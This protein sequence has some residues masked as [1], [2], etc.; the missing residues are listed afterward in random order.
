MVSQQWSARLRKA[1]R[2]L[3]YLAVI[4]YL[5]ALYSKIS[6]MQSDVSAM[7]S[8]I[9]SLGDGTCTNPRLCE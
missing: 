1:G 8:D 2:T 9:S 3:I 6:A 4:V 5:L 7:Q